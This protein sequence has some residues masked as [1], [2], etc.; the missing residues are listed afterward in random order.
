MIAHHLRRKANYFEI[1]FN[2]RSSREDMTR[3][4]DHAEEILERT[5]LIQIKSQLAGSLPQGLKRV[6][7]IAI[8][9]ATSPRLLLLDEPTAGMSHNETQIIKNLIEQLNSQG[10]T[11]ILVEHNMR[12]VMDVCERVIVLNFGQKLAEGP[13]QEIS[14]NRDVI[15][16]YTR[17]KVGGGYAAA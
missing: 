7:E 17:G 11:I 16:A 2:T 10:L 9:L 6:L 13:P 15:D 8:A 12:L 14:N 5:G 1:L 3:I 4:Q